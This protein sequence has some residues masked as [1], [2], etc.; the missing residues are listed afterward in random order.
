M[1]WPGGLIAITI[2]GTMGGAA[3]DENELLTENNFDILTENGF[4]ILIESA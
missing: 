3:L 1:W 4:S 2:Y